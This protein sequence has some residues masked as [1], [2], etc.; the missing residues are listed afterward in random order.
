MIRVLVNAASDVVR[1]GLESMLS[2][3][4]GISVVGSGIGM[5]KIASQ[6]EEL[7]PDVVLVET[8]S[9]EAMA[10]LL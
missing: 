2:T 5:E 9:E 1:T 6:V 3:A 8:P 4:A 7:Q 10:G